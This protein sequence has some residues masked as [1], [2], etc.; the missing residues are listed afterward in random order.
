MPSIIGV[1]PPLA[2]YLPP[3]KVLVVTPVHNGARWLRDCVESVVAQ[4]FTDW[5][6]VLVDDGSTD[7]SFDEM[8][9]LVIEHP[10]RHFLVT[11]T[12]DGPLG[13]GAARNVGVDAYPAFEWIF[14]LD[15]D[16]M[17][18]DDALEKLLAL[19]DGRCGW[20]SPAIRQF[21][22]MT[23]V[24]PVTE[25]P[26]EQVFEI[27]QYCGAS[28]IRASM[29]KTLGGQREDLPFMCD[30]DLW[31]R[32]TH[33]GY[34]PRLLGEPVFLYR[35][36]GAANTYNWKPGQFDKEQRRMREGWSWT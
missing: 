5:A 29:W 10:E 18:T 16:D 11:R 33:A 25:L 21:G 32:A 35:R 23:S 7:D 31:C 4:T 20:I 28:L 17:L 22:D 27:N 36:H 26:Q 15:C 13:C 6:M 19:D 24:I 34:K 2:P 14:P 8:R 12:K 1:P 30:W 9:R 3:V